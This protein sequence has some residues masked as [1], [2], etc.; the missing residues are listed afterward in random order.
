MFKSRILNEYMLPST[1]ITIIAKNILKEIKSAS[2]D[3][4]DLEQLCYAKLKERHPELSDFEL[5]DE[6]PKLLKKVTINITNWIE[7]IKRKGVSPNYEFN[8]YPPNLLIRYSIKYGEDIWVSEL[9]KHKKDITNTIN[10]V[11]WH[12]FEKLCKYILKQKG[13]SQIN[14][15]AK[16]QEG[17]DF[18]GLFNIGGSSS[19]GFIPPNFKIRVIGQIKHYSSNISPGLVRAFHT[20]YESVQRGDTSV[21][22]KLPSWFIEVKSPILGIFMTTSD[23]TRRAI[24]YAE[25][26]WIILKTGE[27]IIED[28]ITSPDA[29]KWFLKNKRGQ[30]IFNQKAFKNSFHSD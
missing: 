3:K 6:I 7:T 11:S 8:T 18:C 26:E 14:L 10:K 20:Y 22:R 4:I 29:Q 12:D 9:R 17:I 24:K 21:I 15:T 30:F 5:A 2:I 1:S 16:N 23:F 13:L 27:Q 19:L 28:L 25:Q